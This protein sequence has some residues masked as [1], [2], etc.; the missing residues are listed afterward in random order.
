MTGSSPPSQALRLARLLRP[1]RNPLARGADRVESA[2]VILFVLLAVVLVPVMLT[3]GSLTYASLGEQ[4]AQQSRSRY[5][6][7]AVL[8]EDAPEATIGTHGEVRGKTKVAARWQLRDGTIRTG[9]V[10]AEDGSKA[11]DEVSVWLD[12]SGRPVS[13]PISTADVVG[14]GVLVAVAG[15]F[16]VVGLLGL[17]LWGLRRMVDRHRYR[18]WDAEW[19]RFEADWHDQSR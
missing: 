8:T 18:M 19:T 16:S 9:P 11:G 14:T 15:W 7:T 13:P 4:S 5:E 2:A 1:G 10:E 3:L 6:T 17:G 12:A